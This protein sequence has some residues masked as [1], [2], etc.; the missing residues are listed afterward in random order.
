MGICEVDLKQIFSEIVIGAFHM[1]VLISC[2]SKMLH[3]S[4]ILKEIIF[5]TQ[6]IMDLGI[7]F[8]LTYF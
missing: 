3:H 4:V 8:H 7:H 6:I 2:L 1:T 5:Q